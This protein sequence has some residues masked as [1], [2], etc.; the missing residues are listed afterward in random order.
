[1]QFDHA[2]QSATLIRRY[3]R[4]L[5]DA[6]LTD[7]TTITLHCPNTGSMKNCQRPGSRIWFTDSANDKRKYPCTWQLIEVEGNEL[8]GINTGLANRL[9]QEA[10]QSGRVHELDP[11]AVLLAEVPYGSQRSRIDFLLRGEQGIPDCY[12]EVKNVSLGV[13]QGRALFPDA[14]TT[15]GQKHLQEL[16]EVKRDGHRAVLMFCVQHSGVEVVA[17]ADEIDPAYGTLLREAARVGVELLAYRV[18]FDLP[19]SRLSLLR[20]LRVEL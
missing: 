9:V 18:E 2:L 20:P 4:F 8:V 6:Q 13:G 15:R 17:P 16:M 11:N 1:M 19:Q 12:I 14:V 5:A 10:I 3:K 7:G